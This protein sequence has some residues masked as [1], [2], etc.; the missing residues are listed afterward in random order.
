MQPGRCG[1]IRAEQCE[2]TF[3]RLLDKQLLFKVSQFVSANEIPIHEDL[4]RY[5]LGMLRNKGAQDLTGPLDDY[6]VHIPIVS[7][8]KNLLIYP[9]APWISIAVSQRGVRSERVLHRDMLH[10]LSDPVWPRVKQ[11]CASNSVSLSA[12][13]C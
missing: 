6:R 11:D 7:L 9:Y 8:N 2:T 1:Q 12:R 10:V 13:Y 3:V 4:S 5:F